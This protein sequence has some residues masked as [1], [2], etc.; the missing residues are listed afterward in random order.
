MNPLVIAT[1]NL[2]KWKEFQVLLRGMEREIVSLKDFSFQLP[3]ETGV[4][5]Q[6][7]AYK[8][9]DFVASQTGFSALADD[10]GF[11]VPILGDFPGIYSA[12]FLN[13][14]S[15]PWEAMKDLF[16]KAELQLSPRNM[17]PK[18]CFQCVLSFVR[19]QEEPVFFQGECWG[20][21]TGEQRG[22]NGFGYDPCFIP[23]G[24][25]RTFAEL[26]LEE[27]SKYSHRNKA[28]DLFLK[29]WECHE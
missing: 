25:E 6:E 21:L 20:V 28:V 7:N 5:F 4:S 14:Y 12:R 27:K 26:S 23:C 1:E 2:G 11:I 16:C 13:E 8:K 18:A 17:P 24:E 15:T 9:A 19:P 3:A 10:S 29:Y 22:S